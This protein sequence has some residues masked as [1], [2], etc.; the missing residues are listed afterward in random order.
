MCSSPIRD[1]LFERIR[2]STANSNEADEE[3]CCTKGLFVCVQLCND[4]LQGYKRTKSM[5]LISLMASV[6]QGDVL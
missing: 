3:S 1:Q 4:I 2:H 6:T 5:N